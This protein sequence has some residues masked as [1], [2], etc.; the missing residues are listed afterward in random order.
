MIVKVCKLFDEYQ[1]WGRFVE[2]LS[3]TY[4][5]QH[6]VSKVI[7]CN[8]VIWSY[9]EVLHKSD[10][11]GPFV[12]QKL[13]LIYSFRCNYIRNIHR[14]HF[15]VLLKSDLDVQQTCIHWCSTPALLANITLRWKHPSLF[16]PRVNNVGQKGYNIG[17]KT[18]FCANIYLGLCE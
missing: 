13:A 16:G 1:S 2:H 3:H 5:A 8:V 11:W 4:V 14:S 7:I 6:S 17:P 18:H 12:E 9:F 10:L 15:V